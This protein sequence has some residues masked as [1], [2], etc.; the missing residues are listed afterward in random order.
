MIDIS[1]F[2]SLRPFH[3][4]E[5]HDAFI[6]M[7]AHPHFFSIIADVF[8]D[9]APKDIIDDLLKVKTSFEFQK[10]YMH[11]G[12]RAILDRSSDGLSSSGFENILPGLP[13]LFL[14]NHRDIFLDSGMLQVLLV[15]HGHETTEISFGS[16]LMESPFL[17]DFGRI[18][19]MFT[20]KRS[21]T[22]KELYE[23]AMLVSA[24]IRY[25]IT[26]KKV[27]VWLA[28]RNGRAKDGNDKTQEGVL[29]MLAM[30]NRKGFTED[31]LPLNLI[32]VSVSY[33][34]EP[35]DF[36]KVQELYLSEQ[37]PYMKKPGED[38][39]SILTGVFQNKGRIHVALSSDFNDVINQIDKI[40][41][42]P[43]KPAALTKEIDKRVYENYKLWKT[44]YIAYDLL[45]G[46]DIYT[47]EYTMDE[48]KDFIEY[49]NQ[50]LDSI[51]GEK[52]LLRKLFLDIY[53]N[54]VKNRTGLKNE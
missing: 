29:K 19:R 28:Q 44:N 18:N 14:S 31:F 16:N 15:E 2:D 53:A 47:N 21:G 1:S 37:G 34:Y 36:L 49:M 39:Q 41:P 45:V 51:E 5:L 7:T 54:P 22:R 43:E 30:E 42:E 12:I 3:N 27:S 24:Y 4:Q 35:C 50:G 13:Y 38:L 11:S 46:N 26:T 10:K 25:V 20:I 17:V 8:P 48:K 9:R 6:R 40:Y 33:E 32:A 23:N 52:D